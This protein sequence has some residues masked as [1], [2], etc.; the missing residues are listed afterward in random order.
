MV[1]R[2]S[3]MA[4]YFI[5]KTKMK[6]IENIYST[7]KEFLINFKKL[8]TNSTKLIWQR[9]LSSNLLKEIYFILFNVSIKL[10]KEVS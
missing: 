9:K 1:N 7:L 8:L 3:C 6:G 10:G 5:H 2:M 4:C